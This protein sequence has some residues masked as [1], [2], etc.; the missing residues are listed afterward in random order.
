MKKRPTVH[1]EQYPCAAINT[2][3]NDHLTEFGIFHKNNDKGAK[4]QI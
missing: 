3:R 1:D 2:L 4:V